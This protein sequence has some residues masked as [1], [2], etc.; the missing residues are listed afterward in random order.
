[1]ILPTRQVWTPR[2]PQVPMLGHL[3][4]HERCGLWAGMGIGKTSV[5]SAFLDALYLSGESHPTLVL[6]PLR[7]ARQVWSN[8]FLKWEHTSSLDV[9]PIIGTQAQRL[10]AMRQDSPVFTINYDV[11]PW[12]VEQW[13]DAWPYRTVVADES[14]YLKGHAV[15]ERHAKKKDG[16]QGATFYSDSGRGGKRAGAL[17]RVAWTRI[18][19][20]IELTG[21]PAPNGLDDLW[22]QLWFLDKGQ[23]LGSNRDAFKKRF[24]QAKYDGYGSEPIP[25]ADEQIHDL[26]KDICLTVDPK[27]WFDLKDPL[28]NNVYVELSAS[29]RK[30][31]KEMEKEFFT[32]IEGRKAEAFNGATKTQKLLQLAN[33]AV[34]VDPAC[35]S[36]EDRRSKEWRLVHDEKI[37][38]LES[39][40][41]ETS[42]AT[43][44]IC[45]EFKSDLARLLKAFPRGRVL[46]SQKD[47]DDFKAGRIP[48]L[49]VH[50]KSAGHGIDGF[51]QVCNNIVFFGHNWSLGQRM[52]VTERIGPMRQMQAGFERP[53]WV[54]NIIARKTIDELVI[55]RHASKREVQ[56]LLLEACKRKSFDIS[57]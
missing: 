39:I 45:Y 18:K 30:H 6:G 21:T 22:G 11:L 15:S 8:E 27:D 10:Q 19:R 9:T 43:L 40:M 33:G 36:D 17:A 32:E 23:R 34:Y 54:H 24:F 16:T 35:E 52:Q 28:V 48:Y 41:H 3:V 51:Q 13:G 7:V 47:E 49:F 38:A 53:V 1:M 25:Y 44:L 31:Y 14:D 5:V 50:P 46:R 57:D 20:F 55:E 26:V 37:E 2:P 4:A 56:D 29:A 12:L 42:G